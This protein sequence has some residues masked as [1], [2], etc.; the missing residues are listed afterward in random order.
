MTESPPELLQFLA[1]SDNRVTVLASLATGASFTRSE[2]QTETGLPRPTVSRILGEFKDR[3]LV[4]SG[5]NRYEVT[6][7]GRFLGGRLHSMFDAVETMQRLQTLLKQVSGTGTDTD[8][9]YHARSELLTPTSADPGAPTRRFADR[10]H[11]AS[12]VR[13]LVPAAIPQ[14]FCV[15][16][17]TGDGQQ[18]VEVVLASGDGAL[19]SDD[20]DV[21]HFA[22]TIDGIAVVGLT[23][24]AG[25]IRGYVETSDA[26]VRSWAETTVEAYTRNASRVDAEV[27]TSSRMCQR[28]V[29]RGTTNS[30]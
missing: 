18:T 7:L 5:A 15:D 13:L 8:G 30:S 20:S 17:T 23:D 28:T 2:L 24:D 19:F 16:A 26:A 9:T 14:L 1:R 4:S 12:R 10:L 6:P 27:L 3:R 22:G 11:A 29:E 21:P 25:T